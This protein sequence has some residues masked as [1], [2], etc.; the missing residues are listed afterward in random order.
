LAIL[1]GAGIWCT[2]GGNPL[3]AFLATALMVDYRD[4]SG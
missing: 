3:F 4:E 1:R 2:S